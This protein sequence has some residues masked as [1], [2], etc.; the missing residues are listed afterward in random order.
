VSV[1]ST[2]QFCLLRMW[3][4]RGDVLAA[5]QHVLHARP[6]TD[7]KRRRCAL[8]SG[9]SAQYF[10]VIA[11]FVQPPTANICMRPRRLF[12]AL[13]AVDGVT[14]NLSLWR[15]SGP[16]KGR[17]KFE[18]EGHRF[19]GRGNESPPHQLGD[20]R[21]AVS[22]VGGIRNGNDRKCI[23]DALDLRAQKTSLGAASFV[24][25]KHMPYAQ[26]SSC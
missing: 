8:H 1:D 10:I 4:R 9:Q 21:G 5:I 19:L 6:H 25:L 7:I 26:L 14:R 13:F 24:S 16:Q 15:T 18:A 11:A 22:S 20:L 23:L 3:S 2:F 17:S 12:A